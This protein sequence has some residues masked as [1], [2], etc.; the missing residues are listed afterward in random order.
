MFGLFKKKTEREKLA[1]Q[2]K[3]LMEESYKLSSTDR[4]ASDAK[5]AEA[6]EIAKRMD[7]LP[8]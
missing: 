1:E 4:Q 3:A 7:A 8:K 2:Y 5:M 6:E